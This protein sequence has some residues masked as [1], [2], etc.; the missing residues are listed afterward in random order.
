MDIKG[1]SPVESAKLELK[2]PVTF[3]VMPDA[4]LTVYGSDSKTYR[5]MM[6]EAARETAE[7]KPEPGEIYEKTTTRLARLVKEIHGLEEEGK[8][9]TDPVRL[10]T[11]Y[12]WIREQV[13]QFVMRRSNFLPKA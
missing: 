4:Y 5:A 3:E 7:K 1:L 2:H 8:A 9:I 10:L 6:V 12:P 11:D 13:D